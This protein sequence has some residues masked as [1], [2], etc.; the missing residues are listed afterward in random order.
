MVV[1][2]FTK[3]AHFYPLKHLY[4]TSSVAATFLNNMVKLHGLLNSIVSYRDKVFTSNFWTKLFELLNIK[5]QMSSAYHPQTDDQTECVNQCL[6]M[7]LRCA[8]NSTPKQWVKWLLLVELWYNSS[9]HSS[10]K[11]SPFKALYGSEPSMAAIPK[12][13]PTNNTDLNTTLAER[14][15]FSELLKDHLAQAQNRMK[16]DANSRRPVHS[17]QVGEQVLLKL[18]PYVQ[19]SVV[20]RTYTKLALK[21]FGPYKIL[22]KI[23]TVVYRL[24]LPASAQVHPVFHVSQ[25]KQFTPNH[26]LVFSELP[27]AP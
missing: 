3:Y 27:T 15:H 6:E 9:Y 21:Y 19:S 14:H 1:D 7:Y 22:Q 5:L 26:S 4:T 23:G 25:L 20:S 2:R 17:F 18:K 16:M 12:P 8:I 11:C 10:L 13:V 24:E